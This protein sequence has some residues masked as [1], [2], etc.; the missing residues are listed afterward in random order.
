MLDRILLVA[1]KEREAPEHEQEPTDAPLVVEVLAQLLRALGV[2]TGEHVVPLAL[3]DQRRLR[4]GTR[5]RAAV[6]DGLRELERAL[7]IVTRCNV[8]AQQAMAPRAP[9]QDVRTKRRS[10]SSRAASN[11]A[12]AVEMLESL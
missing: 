12:T 8:V 10:A 11:N 2:A 4:V 9:L 1:E 3:R 6:A 7:D 5:D